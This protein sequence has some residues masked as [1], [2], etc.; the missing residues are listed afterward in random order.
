[1][2]PRI[3][4]YV[5]QASVR[6]GIEIFADRQVAEL[7]DLGRDVEVLKSI[8]EGEHPFA[9]YGEVIVHKVSSVETLERFPA[10]KTVL[11]VHDHE[12]I[13][14][15]GYAYT[16]LGR[17]CR[18]PGG[19]WPCIMCAP[20]CRSWKAA[21]GRVFSQRRRI[22][23]MSRFRRIVV[24]SEFM[25]GRLAANGIPERIIEVRPP[26]I[27]MARLMAPSDKRDIPER[28][29]ALFVGQLIRGKGVHLLLKA[30]AL[31]KGSW[32][33]DV[34]GAGNMEGEL[35]ELSQK[36]GLADRVRWRGFRQRPQDWMSVAACVVVPSFW[37]EP[38]GLVAAEA[39]ALGRN[40]VAFDVGGLKE[41]SKGLAKLVA[42]G[43]VPGLAAA[44]DAV[45]ERCGFSGN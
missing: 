20:L 27:D 39:V 25:K 3:A 45:M 29:D 8:P 41:A 32:T 10:E 18:R 37:Q 24:I 12:C 13:C 7:R 44:I 22:A 35:K 11:Y 16:P 1:M 40:V 38:F 15:R 34:V 21:L 33:L 30:M 26:K 36:L 9:E 2:Q 17:N 43:D 42:P 31:S 14:P 4:V 23:A 19:V 28:V 6:G 5:E